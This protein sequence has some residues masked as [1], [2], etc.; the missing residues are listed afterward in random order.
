MY[1]YSPEVRKKYPFATFSPRPFTRL[2]TIHGFPVF[3]YVTFTPQLLKF[4]QKKKGLLSTSFLETY[5]NF[6]FKVSD[7]Q[8]AIKYS[9]LGTNRLSIQFETLQHQS[10][11]LNVV[12]ASRDNFPGFGW[13]GSQ[14]VIS[15]DVDCFV[16]IAKLERILIPTHTLL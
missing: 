4:F 12:R 10:E 8:A 1:N 11:L 13:S 3:S 16:S 2:E 7:F 9:D 6:V 5:P 15:F 14:M